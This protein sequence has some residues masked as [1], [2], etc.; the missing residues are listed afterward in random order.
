VWIFGLIIIFSIIFL[1]LTISNIPIFEV[2]LG[3]FSSLIIS[4]IIFFISKNWP[5]PKISESNVYWDHFESIVT[6]LQLNNDYGIRIHEFDKELFVNRLS[7][8]I[9]GDV[10]VYIFKPEILNSIIDSLKNISHL[11][12]HFFLPS[13]LN[14]IET[15][16]TDQITSLNTHTPANTLENKGKNFFEDVKNVFF[17]KSDD[18]LEKQKQYIASINELINDNSLSF[19]NE[20]KLYFEFIKTEY[21]LFILFPDNYYIESKSNKN[22]IIEIDTK[23]NNYFLS[24]LN[25]VNNFINNNSN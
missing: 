13:F 22:F 9:N 3:L 17:K 23:A 21:S 18:M 12:F 2:L 16:K 11:T 19:Y 15:N 5:F 6:L 8:T 20:K 4:V 14:P 10:Y 24:F 7:K 25:L 1:F